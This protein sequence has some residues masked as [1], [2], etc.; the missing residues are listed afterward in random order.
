MSKKPTVTE[1]SGNVFADLG[2]PDAA[3]KLLRAELALQITR[4][5]KELKL[6]QTEA[7][8]R[9]GVA[10]PDISKLVRGQR[11]GFSADRMIAMLNA[12]DLDVDIVVRPAGTSA[13]NRRVRVIEAQP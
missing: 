1:S 13:R 10:Q 4:R 12:L 8:E 11:A 7:G 2:L 5:I 9:L 3:G 6:T